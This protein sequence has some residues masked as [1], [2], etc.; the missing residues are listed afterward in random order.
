MSIKQDIVVILMGLLITLLLFNVG[1]GYETNNSSFFSSFFQNDNYS[2][3]FS[4]A[5][6]KEVYGAD[7]SSS[8]AKLSSD[9]KCMEVVASSLEFPGAYVDFSVDIVNKGNISSSISSVVV[10][11]VSENS[12]LN[13]TVLDSSNLNNKIIQPGEKYN[14]C[15]RIAW[16]E[17]YTFVENE[18]SHFSIKINCEQAY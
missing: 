1:Y 16:K 8:Y 12:F 6:I 9:G 3:V 13:V 11:G 4:N 10:E 5:F 2:V 14:I 17:N 18:V 15:I 7:E